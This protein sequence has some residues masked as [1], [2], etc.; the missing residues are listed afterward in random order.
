MIAQLAN[1]ALD[2]LV[3]DIDIPKYLAGF[4]V[5]ARIRPGLV[6]NPLARTNWRSVGHPQLTALLPEP[7]NTFETP[8]IAHLD[9]TF[10]HL[11]FNRGVNVIILN[12]GDGTIHHAIN[13]AHR[14][15]EAAS[16]RYLG[17]G[18]LLPMPL[19]LFV[20]GGGMNMLARVF[21]TRGH[22]VRTVRRFLRGMRGASFGSLP[23]RCVPLLQVNDTSDVPRYGYIFGS[24]MVFNALAMY[25]RFG[26]G[27]LGLAQLLVE[28]SRGYAFKTEL[29]YKYGHLLDAPESALALD[30]CLY[31]RYSTV[32]ATTVPLQLAK[33]VVGPIRR[34]ATPGG[35]NAL[36]VLPTDKADVIRLIPH[37]M[38]GSP[39]EGVVYRS[40][41]Q[42]IAVRGPYTLDGER[43]DRHDEV[44]DAPLGISGSS[45]VIWGID[46]A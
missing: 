12:G 17:A 4:H 46:L 18:E 23:K 41:V 29:W 11:F 24:E 43:F 22:P 39:N 33:G 27:Y 8:S 26:Q 35:M 2:E 3:V 28:V 30:G 9:A 42:H 37:L 31:P 44:A 40:N 1:R 15:I 7:T 19:F 6:S 21:G 25:E 45:R 5:N 32:V 38:A 14:V 20:N 34:V 10:A 16:S 13:S 36:A